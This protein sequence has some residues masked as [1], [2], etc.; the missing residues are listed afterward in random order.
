[1]VLHWL[2]C[3]KHEAYLGSASLT[4]T[5]NWFLML[6]NMLSQRLLHVNFIALTS[7]FKS[8]LHMHAAAGL[9]SQLLSPSWQPCLPQ[10]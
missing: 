4:V 3:S 2:V 5:Q 8:K 7:P 6:S 1:M 10:Q 9:L